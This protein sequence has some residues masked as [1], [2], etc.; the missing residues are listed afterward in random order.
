MQ[1]KIYKIKDFNFPKIKA[2]FTM[3]L[4]SNCRP[5]RYLRKNRLRNLASPL[6]WMINEKLEVVF[7]LFESDF[8][9]FFLS[10]TKIKEFKNDRIIHVKDNVNEMVSIHHFFSNENLNTQ[11]QRINQQAIKRWNLIKE[12]INNAKS[13]VF[14]RYGNF[15]LKLSSDFLRKI[16]TLFAHR[17]GGYY[18]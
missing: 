18:L 17:G 5:A 11:A 7:D 14:V 3:S 1:D 10:C 16:S 2:D 13:V 9:N 6:D 4:G 15:D 8:K 12:K